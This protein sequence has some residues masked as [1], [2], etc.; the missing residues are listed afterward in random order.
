MRVAFYAP[1]KAPGHPV[2]SGDRAIA[3]LL[4]AALERAGATRGWEVDVASRFRSFDG[5][6]DADRQARL[7]AIGARIADR[8]VHRYREAPAGRSP[9]LWFT[10]HLYHKAP[11][12]IG[13][14]VSERLGI[15]YLVAEASYAAKQRGGAMAH[16]TRGGSGGHSARGRYPRPQSR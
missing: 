11:D 13:P 16:R 14:V 10:Y 3:R 6:G 7:R 1:L 2:P 15:P 9:G 4:L 8:L 5:A 12:W